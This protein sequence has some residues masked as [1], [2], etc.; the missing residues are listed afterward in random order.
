MR[1]GLSNALR[2]NSQD[3]PA[4]TQTRQPA[5][6]AEGAPASSRCRCQGA[7][8]ARPRPGRRCCGNGWGRGGGE[9][10]GRR[11]GTRARMRRGGLV[12]RQKGRRGGG[13]APV[14]RARRRGRHRVD[15]LGH[16]HQVAAQHQDGA[17]VAWGLGFLG[18]GGGTGAE[19]GWAG[20]MGSSPD[21]PAA[22]RWEPAGATRCETRGSPEAKGG[23][24]PTRRPAV[25]CGREER[26]EVALGEALKAVHDALVG[27]HDHLE[28]VLLRGRRRGSGR[29]CE[30]A[31]VVQR[32]SQKELS[33]KW[34]GVHDVM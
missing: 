31:S 10:R 25:V 14:W 32:G 15:E 12:C 1:M 34:T 8:R 20:M 17:G 19:G 21:C 5:G 3:R 11:P 6:V 27:A 9:V 29:V 28:A 18:G 22:A 13:G 16:H 24:A 26:D 23:R 2:F 4:V 30:P 33:R 7:A